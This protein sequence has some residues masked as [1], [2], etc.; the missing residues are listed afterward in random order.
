M[1]WGVIF[2]VRLLAEITARLS[3]PLLSL[4][5]DVFLGHLGVGGI[6]RKAQLTITC[7]TCQIPPSRPPSLEQP[8]WSLFAQLGWG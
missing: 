4:W 5:K 7:Q 2:R 1:G 3:D 8:S 6:L